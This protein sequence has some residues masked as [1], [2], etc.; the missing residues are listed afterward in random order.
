MR[1]NEENG[2]PDEEEEPGPCS[3]VRLGCV[4]K[5]GRVR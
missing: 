5:S 1:E 3:G 2:H 4:P